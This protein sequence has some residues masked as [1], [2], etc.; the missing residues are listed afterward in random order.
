M[1]ERSLGEKNGLNNEECALVL[2]GEQELV[3]E[4]MVNGEMGASF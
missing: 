1:E 4:I 2:L 3:E